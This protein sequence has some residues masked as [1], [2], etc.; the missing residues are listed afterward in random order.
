MRCDPACIRA[1]V[2]IQ[3]KITSGPIYIGKAALGLGPD[4]IGTLV[5]MAA[6][7]PLLYSC[8]HKILDGLEIRPNSTDCGVSCH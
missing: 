1:S 8:N 4:Q 7:S 5:L 6:D 3:I 2:Q